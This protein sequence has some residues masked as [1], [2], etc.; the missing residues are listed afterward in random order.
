M[1]TPPLTLTSPSAAQCAPFR[2]SILSPLWGEGWVRCSRPLFPSFPSVR[3]S[4]FPSPVG[5][6]SRRPDTLRHGSLS[7]RE[8]ARVRGKSTSKLLIGFGEIR[9]AYNAPE[10]TRNP[11]LSDPKIFLAGPARAP[12][13]QGRGPG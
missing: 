7:P 10:R 11:T 2:A 3:Y 6:P 4:P 1:I 9:N 13:P 8:R 12:S 5:V